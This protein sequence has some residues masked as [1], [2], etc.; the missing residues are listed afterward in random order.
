MVSGLARAM[1]W[2]RR[3]VSR[4]WVARL[5]RRLM[6][7]VACCERPKI[8]SLVL[9]SAICGEKRAGDISEVLSSANTWRPA[10]RD[11]GDR[12]FRRSSTT[13]SLAR[14]RG[15]VARRTGE[16]TWVCAGPSNDF[17]KKSVESRSPQR[18]FRDAIGR[19][20]QYAPARVIRFSALQVDQGTERPGLAAMWQRSAAYFDQE[21]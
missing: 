9:N 6:R 21:L 13:N 12:T 5:P 7:D 20:A 19:D 11:Y 14:N 2:W 17:A 15:C 4:F 10:V 3:H 1:R 18:R 16:N 8:S